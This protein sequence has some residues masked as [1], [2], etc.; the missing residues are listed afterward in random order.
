MN[1]VSHMLPFVVAGGVLIAVSFLWGIYSADP[2]SDQ[3]NKIAAM[4]KGIGGTAFSMIVPIFTAFIA[5]SIAGRSGMVA[6]LLVD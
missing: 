2:A 3:Y 6:G 5:S 4:L 1:G